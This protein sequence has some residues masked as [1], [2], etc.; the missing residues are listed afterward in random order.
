[1][2][3]RASIKLVFLGT[4]GSYP[5]PERN[6][7]SI[8]LK[9]DS[10]VLLFDCGEGTQRQLMSSSLSFMKVDKVFLTHL[11]GDHILGLSGLLQSMN[12]NDRE[13]AVE[14]FGP[15]DTG[16]VLKDIIFKGY[17]RPG[18]PVHITELQPSARLDFGDFSVTAIKADH[19]VPTLAY[20]F[21]ER[22][23]KGRFN[24][25]KA[26]DM[27]VPEGPLFSKIH[28]GE[29]ITIADKVIGPDEIVGPPR[30]GKKVF[31]SGDTKPCNE[32]IE[33]AF[34]SDVLIHDSTLDASLSD[35][36]L[37]HHHSTAKMAA[38]VARKAEV[39]RLYLFHISPRYKDLDLLEEQAKEIFETSKVPDDLS[40]YSL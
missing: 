1:M 10:E 15:R 2:A 38:E 21:E 5:I 14:I 17:F 26:L 6:V 27:G 16:R 31:Y 9:V 8:A 22:D 35:A 32:I 28:R 34:R 39:D 13:K 18:F 19:N 36:A 40:E 30:R 3:S 12:M 37:R 33:A 25:K 23:K 11:H 24:K 29:S 4:G 20:L 7:S